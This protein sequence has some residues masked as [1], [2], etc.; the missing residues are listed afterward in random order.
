MVI[1][2]WSTP[3]TGSTW[4]SY[5]LKR[6]LSNKKEN[7]F[8]WSEPF[9]PYHFNL[10]Y[11]LTPAGK[12]LS[13]QEFRPNSFWKRHFLDE[14][15]FLKVENVYS[16]K[17]FSWQDYTQQ[18]LRILKN[19]S[20]EMTLILHN[21]LFPME[22]QH[23]QA[24]LQN[25]IQNYYTFRRDLKSQLASYAIAYHTKEFVNFFSDRKETIFSDEIADAVVLKN[26]LMRIQKSKDRISTIENYIEVPFEEIDFFEFEHGPK[27][28]NVDSWNQLCSK[29]QELILSLLTGNL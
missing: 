7:I 2:V 14:N 21:H 10:H 6:K 4:L 28:Q 1:N 29:D 19:I 24:C 26:L 22:D 15:N 9:N 13:H 3:R 8:F 23:F 20:P 25:C 5:F 12:V 16:R 17:N 27:K 11:E 18:T